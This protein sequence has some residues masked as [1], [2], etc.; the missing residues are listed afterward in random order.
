MPPQT[1]KKRQ[2]RLDH[3]RYPEH[4]RQI[5]VRVRRRVQNGTARIRTPQTNRQTAKPSP[6]Q[7]LEQPEERGVESDL[8]QV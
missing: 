1:R 3:K 8:G 7:I 2:Y 4:R 6:P 5:D